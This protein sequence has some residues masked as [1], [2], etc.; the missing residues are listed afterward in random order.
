M[1][2][3]H[4]M[5]MSSLSPAGPN[6]MMNRPGGLARYSH[7][8]PVS[9]PEPS[10]KPSHDDHGTSTYKPTSSRPN[11]A[12]RGRVN[13]AAADAAAVRRRD[14][15]GQWRDR[16]ARDRGRPR[17]HAARHL[18]VGERALRVAI[19]VDALITHGSREEVIE[20]GDAGHT[21]TASHASEVTDGGDA[22]VEMAAGSSN[23]RSSVWPWLRLMVSA[24]A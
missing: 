3:A 15:Y 13:A 19:G 8:R 21:Y 6:V 20:A 10:A 11:A 17:R 4:A 16:R 12:L 2:S 23:T 14:S 7:T 18:P 9:K 1:S 5:P 24:H 22:G